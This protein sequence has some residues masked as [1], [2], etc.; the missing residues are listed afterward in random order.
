MPS[1]SGK[2]RA[3]DADI[4]SGN[5]MSQDANAASRKATGIHNGADRAIL[6]PKGYRRGTGDD[7]NASEMKLN[8]R[9]KL[10]AGFGLQT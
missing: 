2:Q 10:G 4:S 6:N 9:E 8:W 1:C 7:L 3:T 5:R